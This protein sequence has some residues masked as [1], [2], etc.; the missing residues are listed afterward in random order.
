MER[1]PPPP[2]ERLAATGRGRVRFALLCACATLGGLGAV[3]VAKAAIRPVPTAS[4][5]C[6]AT[7]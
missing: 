4:S 3:R 7:C 1:M 6:S 5:T 2:V